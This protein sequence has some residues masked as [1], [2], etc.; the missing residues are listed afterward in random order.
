MVLVGFGLFFGG[1]LKFFVFLVG[2]LWF[3]EVL[4]GSWEF[5]VVLCNSLWF[6]VVLGSSLLIV[7]LVGAW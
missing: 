3:L 4:G 6:L 2:S 7:V 5:F 1:S